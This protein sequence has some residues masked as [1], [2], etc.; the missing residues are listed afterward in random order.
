MPDAVT[1]STRKRRRGA[2]RLFGAGVG[3]LC[4]LL[5]ARK[6]TE[7]YQLVVHLPEGCHLFWDGPRLARVEL[8]RLLDQL[9]YYAKLAMSR[10]GR[11]HVHVLVPFTKEK[12]AAFMES[13]SEY[14]APVRND[15]HLLELARYLSK[16]RIEG[17]ARPKPC[18]LARY[19]REDLEQQA[20]DAAE[21]YL[22][23]QA[24]AKRRGLKQVP[25][26]A[27]THN[28]PFLKPDR[29][30]VPGLR[31]VWLLQS[32][33]SLLLVMC[34]VI[35]LM[36]WQAQGKHLPDS[37]SSYGSA[38]LPQKKRGVLPRARAPPALWGMESG[39]AARCPVLRLKCASFPS[40]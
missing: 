38:G 4:R 32:W 22:E 7:L 17:A 29:I 15:E 9:P 37:L 5:L 3:V 33:I 19:S 31:A 6:K 25:R 27:W 30:P 18:D 2:E 20:L 10:T 12:A 34:A 21:F 39:T 36:A 28:L 23:A 16:P 35:H 14:C 26:L 11:V 24:E 1:D 13:N 8:E 40:T